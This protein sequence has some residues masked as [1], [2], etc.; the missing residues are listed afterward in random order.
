METVMTSLRSTPVVALIA[1][2]SLAGSGCAG[3]ASPG[4]ASPG[5]DSTTAAPSKAASASPATASITFTFDSEPVVTRALT[6]IDEDYIN[7]GAVI[8]HDATLHMYANV[9]TS[10]PGR[11]VVPHLTSTDGRSWTLATPKLA[12]TS[13]DVPLAE[14]GFDV[15]AGFVRP[16]GTWVLIFETVEILHPWVLGTATAP[17]PDGPWTVSPD[18]ILE[19]G[20]E[21]AFDAGGLSW[22]SVVA[23]GDGYAMYYAAQE[24]QRGP[25]TIAMATSSDGTTWSKAPRPVLEAALPWEARKV[26]R[27][28]VAVTSRG[29]AMVYSGGR[30]TDRGLA[31]SD[32]GVAWVRDGDLPVIT[33][34]DFPTGVGAWDAA[35]IVRDDVLHYYLEIGTASGPTAS[36]EIYLATATVP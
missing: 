32:D 10:W 2:L 12:L 21:G 28:R 31:W 22:P 19:A 5:A 7:P 11:V 6:T 33:R 30:I 9:F 23:H 27:P 24:R 13:D 17:G 15:S 26:D 8:E 4:P 3:A 18:P 25:S 35:L 36:T 1:T 16:D 14:P 29:L 34:V 20:D